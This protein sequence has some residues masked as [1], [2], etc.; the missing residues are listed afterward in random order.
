MVLP[1]THPLDGD[2]HMIENHKVSLPRIMLSS[3]E[4]FAY[5]IPLIVVPHI[6]NRI[7]TLQRTDSVQ[8]FYL[9][10][11]DHHSSI[12]AEIPCPRTL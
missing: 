2:L 7:S 12:P 10:K 6:T 11:R 4:L 1:P 5:K 3:R 9:A 8:R